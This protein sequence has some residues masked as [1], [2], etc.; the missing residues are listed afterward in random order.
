VSAVR[1]ARCYLA[2]P[3]HRRRM[4]E[5]A[6][7]APVDAVFMDLEDAVPADEKAAALAGACAALAELDWGDKLVVVRLNGLSSGGTAREVAA[8][9]AMPRLDGLILPKTESADDL[10]RVAVWLDDD[11]P[12][13]R[14]ALEALIETAAGL[15][16]ADAIAAAGGRLAA[17]HF[18]VGDFA[19][20]IG[21]RSTEI[22]ESPPGYAH[23]ARDGAGG[24][25]T[26]ALDLWTY[27]MM[28]LLV[29]ARA[30]GL[31]VIDGPCGAFR[32]L[33]LTAAA[34][35]KAAAM[36]FDGKQAIHPGQIA[37]I[38]AA[39]TPSAAEADYA[40]RVVAAMRDAQAA[41]LGAVSLDGKMLDAANLRMAERI[42]ALTQAG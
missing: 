36:G 15:V 28:R 26:A 25:V 2:V 22:G 10:A 41:G 5:A 38:Q 4:V 18:G 34:A 17:L 29:A 23:T 6:A 8:L 16:Q 9:A 40:A 11:D 13:G 12:G 42:L 37:P 20:S 27:P 7:K 32:D 33:E 1:I 39:F 14:I 24:I 31:R 21:A 30:Y 3:A 19:A 35:A